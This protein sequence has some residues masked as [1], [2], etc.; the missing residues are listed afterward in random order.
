MTEREL[1]SVGVMADLAFTLAQYATTDVLKV[2][3]RLGHGATADEIDAVRVELEQRWDELDRALRQHRLHQ[4]KRE[5][6]A[7][8]PYAED[9]KDMFDQTVRDQF[10]ALKDNR[11]DL[12]AQVFPIKE[13]GGTGVALVAVGPAKDHIMKAATQYAAMAG[14]LGLPVEKAPTPDWDRPR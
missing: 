14:A 2:T 12:R 13:I 7:H 8:A 9:G 4:F 11:Q 3:D 6:P 10:Q 1:P 5:N